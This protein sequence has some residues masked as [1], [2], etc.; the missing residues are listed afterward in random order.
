MSRIFLICSLAL[1]ALAK[2]DLP[3]QWERELHEIEDFRNYLTRNEEKVYRLPENVV[4][5]EYD[6]N[7][8]LYFDERIDR[9]FSFDGQ[10]NIVI[11]VS[12]SY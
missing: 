3:L 12:F 10:V 8:N 2:A 6:I 5:I 11:Q 4:P 1:L 9:P 7:I